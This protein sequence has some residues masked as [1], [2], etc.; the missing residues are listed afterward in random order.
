ML[1]KIKLLHRNIIARQINVYPPTNDVAIKKNV[2]IPMA[3]GVTL[4]ANHYSPKEVGEFPTVLIRSPWG[5]ELKQAPFSLLYSYVAQRFAE[6]G[7]H[8]LL[9][10]IRNAE[11]SAITQVMPHENE[12]QDGRDTLQWLVGQTWF[13]GKV[14]FWGAS[15]LGYV[16][17]AALAGELPQIDKAVMVPATTSTRWFTI[18]HPSGSLALDTLFRLQYTSAIT[19]FTLP[20]LLGAMR[21]QEQILIEQFNQLPLIEAIKPLPKVSG[22]NFEAVMNTPNFQDPLWQAIDLRDKLDSCPAHVHFV[23]GWYDI[24]LVEQLED[25]SVLKQAGKEPYLTIGPWHH[26]SQDL[27]AHTIRIALSWFDKH[28]KGKELSTSPVTIWLQGSNTWLNLENWPP[29]TTV[30][31]YYLNRENSLSETI[32][33][34]STEKVQYRYDPFDP[35]PSIGG[36]VLGPKPAQQNNLGVESR[37]DVLTFD[38]AKLSEAVDIIGTPIVTLFVSSS[39]NHTDFFARLCDVQEDGSSLNV[40][41]NLIRLEF[42]DEDPVIKHEI[43]IRLWPTAYRFAKGHRIRLQISSGAHPR[44]N[45]N[46]GYGEQYSIGHKGQVAEQTLFYGFAHPSR[47]MLPLFSTPH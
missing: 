15:Y 42:A 1:S 46:L 5:R 33:D 34:Y 39:L 24:F 6:R 22:F 44:W 25:Y 23:A 7:Y 32:P 31:G 20:K 26:T 29:E 28:L 19:A 3:D 11:N 21:K 47:I 14:A 2:A 38:T 43:E 12:V 40:T 8:V 41:D 37:E 35:T 13:N 30:H 4:H 45:R 10:D 27:G 16:Q 18:F 9:Q 36:P 17:W